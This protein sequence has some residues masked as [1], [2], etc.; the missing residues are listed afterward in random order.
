MKKYKIGIWGQSGGGGK[1][2]DGQ[3]V[4]TAIITEE[5][6]NR[7]G[8]DQVLFADTYNWRNRPFRFLMECISMMKKSE[9]VLILPADNGFKVFV[10]IMMVLNVIFKKRLVY[11]VIGGFL[12][13]LLKKRP[14]YVKMVNKFDRIFVQ[15]D[16][17]KKDLEEL[18]I[19]NIYIL[20]NLKRLNTRESKDIILNDDKQ[21]K[22][23]VFSRINKEKGIEDAIEAVK[24]A[25]RK[26]NGKF[27]TLDMYGLVPD[28]YKERLQELLE[29]NKGLVA[30][31]GIVYFNKTV[32]TLK[33][34]FALLF[35]TYYY[36]EG[37]PGNVVDAYNTG[38][39]I[40][41]TDWLYN[42]DIIKNGVN[43]ILVPIKNPKAICDAI[44]KLYNN[45]ELAV[46]IGLNNIE[47]SKEYQPNKVLKELYEFLG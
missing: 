32:E 4:R 25:N 13:E 26:L 10:P 47:A 40:I 24:L 30:Y 42:S 28:L 6:K 41:A 23:C 11:I 3:A 34:Y 37:F 21:I 35:P 22:L 20:S 7:Y 18:N 12:P 44:L 31:K 29:E 36:G 5:L 14:V 16:N 43:G 19:K 27:I 33:E 1:I 46:E 8:E 38:L 2:A 45:R 39:P 9:N 17:L 15:T